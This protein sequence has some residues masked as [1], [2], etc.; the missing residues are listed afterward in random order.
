MHT[1]FVRAIGKAQTSWQKEA[2]DE[3]KTRLSPY[4]Q[5]QIIEC[6]EGHQA[7]AKPDEEKTRAREAETLLVS[8]PAHAYIIAL[9]EQG[10]NLSSIQFAEI[11]KEY[12]DRPIVFLIGGSWGLHASVRAQAHLTISLGKQTL[13]HLLARIV[14]IEQLY[15]VETILQGKTYHK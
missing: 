12:S 5:V 11:I 10:R 14:L 13:P 7:S 4:A 3:Y 1:F 9:D 8:L 15:R 2:L 6:S